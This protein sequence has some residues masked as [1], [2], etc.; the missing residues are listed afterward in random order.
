MIP[1]TMKSF[2]AALLGLCLALP[3]QALPPPDLPPGLARAAEVQQRNELG[4]FA[5]EG[6]VGMGLAEN[7]AGKSVI[8]ILTSRRGIS[9]LPV[10][11]EGEDVEVVV[12]GRFIAGELAAQSD[13][14]S[15]TE[16][17]PRPVPIGVS[18]GHQDV[19]AGTLGCLVYQSGGCHVTEFILSNNHILANSNLGADLN[20]IVQP[21]PY[22][23][24]TLPNDGIA[25]LAQYEPII[26]STSANNV[27]DAAIAFSSSEAVR[28]E[29]PPDGYGSIRTTALSATLNLP[30]QKYGRTSRVTT[31]L[32]TMLNATVLVDYGS[33]TARFVQQIIITGDNN[34]PFTLGGDSGSLVVAATGANARRPVGLAFASGGNLSVA[35]PIGPILSR[36]GVQV[37]GVP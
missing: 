33:G 5:R 30:V 29:T 21:G 18:V 28:S 8:R 16:R 37:S 23:G 10:R 13:P 36:F 1:G 9:G 35:N 11:L 24:G 26:F 4:I 2:A 15:P 12:T 22:D 19:T 32:V 20:P 17:W 3:V 25:A 27:M 31:G 7:A 14:S 34:S 6:V